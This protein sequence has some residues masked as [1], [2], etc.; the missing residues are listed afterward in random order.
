MEVQA[1]AVCKASLR[2]CAARAFTVIIC[3]N[4]YLAAGNRVVRGV[5]SVRLCGIG[6]L[7]SVCTGQ[8]T[9]PRERCAGPSDFPRAATGSK[10]RLPAL[11]GVPAG[12]ERC[13]RFRFGRVVRRPARSPSPGRLRWSG[14]HLH[15]HALDPGAD[16]DCPAVHAVVQALSVRLRRLRAE[17][18]G[19]ADAAPGGGGASGH[20]LARCRRSC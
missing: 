6:C 9:A 19:V 5:Y 18:A 10:A 13:R 3:G 20:L 2:A 15:G 7:V 4:S 14:D 12:R 17:R 8:V 16:G 11:A 1:G